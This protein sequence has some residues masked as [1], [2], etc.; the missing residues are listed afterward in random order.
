MTSYI[1]LQTKVPHYGKSDPLIK[2][3]LMTILERGDFINSLPNDIKEPSSSKSNR[4]V[5]PV[6]FQA[7]NDY[8]PQIVSDLIKSSQTSIDELRRDI[9]TKIRIGSL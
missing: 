5:S 2:D 3:A 6:R 1:A 7:L 9:H 8:D 4:G